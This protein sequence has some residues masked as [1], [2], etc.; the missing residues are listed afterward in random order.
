MHRVCTICGAICGWSVDR[1]VSFRTFMVIGVFGVYKWFSY[2]LFTR[3]IIPSITHIVLCFS[4]SVNR[5]F[6]PHSTSPTISTTNELIRDY[7][8]K[9]I[10]QK[11]AI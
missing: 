5:R 10:F 4:S 1:S 9:G 6:Y 7:Y 3:C 2:A 11:G 8:R